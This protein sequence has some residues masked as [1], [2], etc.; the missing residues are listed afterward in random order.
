LPL[1]ALKWS[2]LS[3]QAITLNRTVS[4]DVQRD[5]ALRSSA[6]FW[7]IF[8]LAILLWMIILAADFGTGVMPTLVVLGT[9]LTVMNF[10]FRRRSLI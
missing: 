6:V 5:H 2:G 4:F 8:T 10:A 1:E 9:I 3:G 7:T